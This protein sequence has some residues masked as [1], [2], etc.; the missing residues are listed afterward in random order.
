MRYS[1]T[2]QAHAVLQKQ[3]HNGDIVIDATAGNG[4]DSLFLAQQ[5]APLG[6]VYSFDIQADALIATANRLATARLLANVQLI[7]ANHAQMNQYVNIKHHSKIQAIMF[8]LGYLPGSDKSITTQADTTIAALI[9]AIDLLAPMGLM[10]ILAYPGHAAGSIE[11]HY[12][13]HWCQQLPL[14]HFNLSK[15]TNESNQLTAPRLFVVQKYF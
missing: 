11:A 14:T 3:L 6:S 8:N 9:Q 13:N 1:L 10:T 4:H 15:F 2:Q 7:Q 12:V 5:I